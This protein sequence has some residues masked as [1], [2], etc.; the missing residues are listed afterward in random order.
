MYSNIPGVEILVSLLK[1]YNIKYLVVSPGT[2]NTA[3]VHSLENDTFFKCY[4]IVDE[5]SAAFFALGLA[6]SLNEPV[7]VTCTA[8]TAT[9]NYMP[10]IKEA[11]ER[12]IKL[13]ALTADQ[14]TYSRFHMGDQNINQVNMFDGYVNYAIDVPK[15]LNA[16]DYWY[17]NRMANEALQALYA[18]NGPIQINFRMDYSLNELSTFTKSELP[19]T[20]FIKVYDK[21]IKW[22]ETSKKLKDKKVI[23][24]AG[25]EYYNDD[26]LKKELLK[27]K[28][29]QEAVILGDYYSNIIDEE[30]INPSVLGDV[31]GGK[32]LK[33]LK[34]DI[35]ILLG[36][37]VYANVKFRL[38]IFGQAETWQISKDGRL[39][40]LFKNTRKLFKCNALEFFENINA[41]I[42]NNKNCFYKNWKEIMELI[43]YPNL[44]FTNFYVI[45]QICK[46][47]AED[48]IMHTSVLDAIRM[49][50][51]FK[52]KSNVACFANI[53]ADGI[54]GAL[55]TFL[56]QA[57][58]TDK[59]A[60][61]I[62]GDLS[63]L[64]DIDAMYMNIPSNVRIILI[65]NYGGA[66][67]HKNF[68][69]ERINTINDYIAAG[70]T[71][72]FEK[73]I[74]RNNIEYI[75]AKNEI[76]LK[77]NLEK[78]NQISE[79]PIIMEVFTN[80]EKDAKKLK[81][82]W[83]YNSASF[84]DGRRRIISVARKLLGEKGIENIKKMKGGK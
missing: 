34:P 31:Y 50:N 1:Q 35:I 45:E 62:I 24:F 26:R 71:I 20:R 63:F 83:S 49:S 43:K 30:V 38:D 5:R 9:C 69:I 39:C 19:K 17:F 12:K 84:Q 64:Y 72:E 47:V 60:Y 82:F 81:E 56:G 79:R 61:L 7:C 59:L 55:S 57:S 41:N 68:G 78:I 77:N 13:V 70:H 66:E 52:I 18:N 75:S 46:N 40:D 42:E 44:E 3:L 10:A 67:F 73:V 80:I 74:K 8:A 11:F 2:R 48:S 16:N 4:S 25:S 51:Y 23:V 53:G 37:V 76:E 6:E 28:N 65:N 14:D 32:N 29:K 54:D 22:D 15:V 21:D 33:N 27:F 36:S 58:S